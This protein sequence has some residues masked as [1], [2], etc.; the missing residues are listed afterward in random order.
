MSI[1]FNSLL[2]V[3]QF[4]KVF[5]NATIFFY[6]KVPLNF[7]CLLKQ[8]YEKFTFKNCWEC[9]F[10]KNNVSKSRLFHII[11]LETFEENDYTTHKKYSWQWVLMNKMWIF[12]S[13]LCLLRCHRTKIN[14]NIFNVS[15][16]NKNDTPIICKNVNTTA[17]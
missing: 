8:S 5:F 16:K 7:F 17:A 13:Y 9:N 12:V 14:H 10:L 4:S 15:I 3:Y 2:F 6:S 11:K 1:S